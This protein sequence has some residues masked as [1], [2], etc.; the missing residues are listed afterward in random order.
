MDEVPHS[1]DGDGIRR[2]HDLVDALVQLVGVLL[3]KI[4]EQVLECFVPFEL[5][6]L[7]DWKLFNLLHLLT[8][9]LNKLFLR[10]VTDF[11]FD[12]EEFPQIFCSLKQFPDWVF[13]V[14][15]NLFVFLQ[16]YF[17]DVV[18]LF[19]VDVDVDVERGLHLFFLVGA[20]R[21]K[22]FVGFWGENDDVLGNVLGDVLL[23]LLLGL[24]EGVLDDFAV[25]GFDFVGFGRFD[26]V[27]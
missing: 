9:E 15:V 7:S 23:D 27:L 10:E 2:W 26:F 22:D 8:H 19:G 12:S 11:L 21:R 4:V 24:S 14:G 3:D 1:G 25:F 20:L 17:R 16:V 18:F 5:V 13:K 6:D